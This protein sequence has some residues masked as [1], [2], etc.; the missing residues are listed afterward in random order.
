[1]CQEAYVIFFTFYDGWYV[2]DQRKQIHTSRDNPIAGYDS[3]YNV[4]AAE[5][6]VGVV[7][8]YT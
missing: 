7:V 1:M 2:Y 4:L 6:Q 8:G 3:L 5:D